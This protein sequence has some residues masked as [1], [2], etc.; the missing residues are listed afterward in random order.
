[1]TQLAGVDSPKSLILLTIILIDLI[2]EIDYNLNMMKT[3]T[4]A[5]RIKFLEAKIEQL[6]APTCF[7]CGAKVW[8]VCKRGSPELC[9][10]DFEGG[11]FKPEKKL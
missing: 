2:I 3:M 6:E 4:D 9:G 10:R 7:A 8:Q 11:S 1:L 5:E